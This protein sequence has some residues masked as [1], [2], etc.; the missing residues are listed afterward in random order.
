MRALLISDTHFGAWTGHDLLREPDALARL[1]PHLDDV[2]EVIILGDLF[3]LL[4]ACAE[5]AFEAAEP[6]LE[7]LRNKLQG[8]RVVF[9]P[10]NHDHHVIVRQDEALR[11]ARLFSPDWNPAI[12]DQVLGQLY[13]RRF[14]AQRMEGVEL[15]LRYPTYMVGRVLC[16]HGHYLDP[17]ASKEGSPADRLLGRLTWSI[18]VGGPPDP[19]EIEQYEALTTLLTEELYTLAQLPHGTASQ[20]NV[21]ER[22]QRVSRIVRRLDAPIMLGERLFRRLRPDSAGGDEDPA[23]AHTMEHYRQ[24]KVE[25][26]ER[27]ARTGVPG[28]QSPS[29]PLARMVRPSDPRERALRAFSQ[30]VKNLGWDREADQIV[31]AHTHQPLAGATVAGSNIRYWNS[32]SWIYEPDLSSH[33]A[34]VR[35]LRDGWPGTA[36]LIDTDEPEPQLL[37]LRRDLNPLHAGPA[38]SPSSASTTPSMS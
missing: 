3:D 4:F 13:F 18:S 30:V 33:Q 28:G 25:E 32:G 6:L 37:E 27:A 15:D 12:V 31:F 14:L 24:A 35:Y 20:R 36:I 11:E 1:S 10:G 23:P 7:L 22:A 17:H 38:A 5:D 9:I 34:Y 21:Y 19:V 2:D 26:G 8:K 16:T 29:Y